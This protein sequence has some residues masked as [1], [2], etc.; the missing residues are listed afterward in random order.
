MATD[1]VAV[2]TSLATFVIGLIVGKRSAL[3]LEKRKEW[4]DLA[5]E[6]YR[7]LRFHIQSKGTSGGV[8]FNDFHT[9][10]QY[11]NWVKRKRFQTALKQYNDAYDKTR[12]P[13]DVT[14][15][16]VPLYSEY[17]PA[18]IES[19]IKLLKYLMPR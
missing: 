1:Y 17:M 5:S 4:N 19:A 14:K 12:G 3:S 13:Y 2:G 11:M 7:N 9:M 6:P 16:E 10:E 15:G 18:L 8:R